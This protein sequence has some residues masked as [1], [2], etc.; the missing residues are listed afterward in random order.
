MVNN[1]RY[2]V[3][4]VASA[5]T[6]LL[7]A[8]AAAPTTRTRSPAHAAARGKDPVSSTARGDVVDAYHGV[9]VSDP[10]RWFEDAS[11]QATKDWVTAQN[12]L[13]QPFLE[14]PAATRLARR[15]AQTTL[16]LRK[17]RRSAARRR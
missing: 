2:R 6:A 7:V 8:C 5:S 1:P 16:E 4:F 13:A 10:Y 14:T 9:S 3:A 15:A 12:A 17:F 11:A